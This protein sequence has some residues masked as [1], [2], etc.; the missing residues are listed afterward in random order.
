M[1]P[2]CFRHS[3]VQLQTVRS[4]RYQLYVLFYNTASN[5]HFVNCHLLYYIIP[6]YQLWWKNS[7]YLLLKLLVSC[8]NEMC[9]CIQSS[10]CCI[11]WYTWGYAADSS[12]YSYTQI[13]LSTF[14]PLCQ[15][16]LVCFFYKW[17]YL[18]LFASTKYKTCDSIYLCN[19]DW[20]QS[21]Y[22]RI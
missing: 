3:Y 10:W 18:C 1:Y 13:L 2:S 22:T 17:Q 5:A 16:L 19:K 12:T 4:Q 21:T 14:S 9:I 8:G 11:T 7:F 6:C 15:F 20:T